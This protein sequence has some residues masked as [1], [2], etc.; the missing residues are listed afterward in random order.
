ML[1]DFVGICFGHQIIGRA[2]EAKLGVN[3][4]GWEVSAV[5]VK[6]TDKG[7]EIFPEIAQQFDGSMSIMQFHRDIVMEVPENTELLGYTDVCGVQG[8]YRPK[9]VF[10]LQGHPEFTAE[11]EKELIDIWTEG[12]KFTQDLITSSL[13]RLDDRNDGPLLAKAMVRFILE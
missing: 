3:P 5:P 10:T 9:G 4:N 2:L 13:S 8:F 7:K 6:L 1:A 11:V 12:G